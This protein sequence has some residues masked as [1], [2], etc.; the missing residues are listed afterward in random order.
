MSDSNATFSGVQGLIYGALRRLKV[1][2]V[3]HDIS[4][5][6]TPYCD[7]KFTTLLRYSFPGQKICVRAL[8]VYLAGR[9]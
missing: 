6:G 2:W 9:A 7:L 4:W 8:H 5:L 3:Q 1:Y